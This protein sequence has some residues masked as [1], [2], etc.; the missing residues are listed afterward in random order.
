MLLYLI[1]ENIIMGI[2]PILEIVYVRVIKV[3]FG[4]TQ[5]RDDSLE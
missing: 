1:N 3:R 2:N 5:R 4:F